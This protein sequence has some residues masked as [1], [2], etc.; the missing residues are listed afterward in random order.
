[1]KKY[2]T[3][4]TLFLAMTAGL[5]AQEIMPPSDDG[6]EY[7]SKEA[8]LFTWG[9][10]LAP[11]V[12]TDMSGDDSLIM[13][14]N[15][16]R[17]WANITLPGSGRLFVRGRESANILVSQENRPVENDFENLID[18]DAAFYEYM[19]ADSSLSFSLGRKVYTIGAGVLFAGRGDGAEAGYAHSAFNVKLFS[20]YS[21][22][23]L[24]E[25]NP[26]GMSGPDYTDGSKRLFSGADISVPVKGHVPYV[27]ALH[28]KDFSEEEEGVPSRYDS[29]YGGA[30]V[31]GIVGSG[32]YFIE[33]WY[34]GGEGSSNSGEKSSVSA[35]GAAAS[36]N[37]FFKAKYSPSASVQYGV[38]SGDPD[39]LSASGARDNTAGD[40]T[41]F[42]AFGYF[43]AGYAFRPLFSNIHI[44]RAGGAFNP[45]EG[46]G[47]RLKKF[48][49][50]LKYSY[51]MKY[52]EK[53]VVNYGEGDNLESGLGHAA[54]LSLKWLPYT[55]L[56]V[57]AQYGLFVPGAAFSDDEPSRHFIMIGSNLSF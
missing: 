24:K 33:G 39:R 37:W 3:A 56:A 5:S 26:Y 7:K 38:A 36:L 15:G 27:V 13:S 57:F 54:D 4:I 9:G 20:A 50:G 17:L 25:Y 21:G 11:V 55:D 53:G 42:H 49:A 30:G 16:L 40:D 44:F 18:L 45:F 41:A 2:I 35:F 10:T 8:W 1:M 12:V 52:D 23:L 46:F 14:M 32:D 34:Q 31:K 22:L 43:P 28:Q 47:S 19:P 29:W 51:Y 6:F 48:T